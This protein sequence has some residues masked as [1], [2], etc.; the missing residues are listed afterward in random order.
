MNLLKALITN[1]RGPIALVAAASVAACASAPETGVRDHFDDNRITSVA[2][3]PFYSSASFGLPSPALRDLEDSY[4]QAATHSLRR[5]GFQV[6]DSAALEEHLSARDAWES[7]Q[8]GIRLRAGL[9]Y[10]F[11][12]ITDGQRQPIEIATLQN[13]AQQGALPAETILV[14]EIVYHSEG[15]C[16]QR[17]DDFVD[18]A[19]LT[20]TDSAPSKLPRPCVTA[21]FRSK[22]VD[23]STG[24]TMWFNQM[25]VETHTGQ[26]DAETVMKT[27]TAAVDHTLQNDDGLTPLAP[28]S[29]EMIHA[30]ESP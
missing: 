3:V 5:Q 22:L 23:T 29:E 19:S 30:G 26:I 21:H 13:L 24:Q 9:N 28:Q 7:F 14:G 20:I 25:L 17:A 10:Y 11:E 6:V 8:E 27:I 16:R 2:V 12:P 15:T 4:E 18:L 1:Y